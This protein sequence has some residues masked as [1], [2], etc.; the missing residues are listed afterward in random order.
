M[1]RLVECLIAPVAV[2]ADV[3][4]LHAD[5]DVDTLARHAPLRVHRTA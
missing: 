3:P 1:R 2:E 4:I 5:G